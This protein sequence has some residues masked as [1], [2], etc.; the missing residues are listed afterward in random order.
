MKTKVL[1][2]IKKGDFL[3]DKIDIKKIRELINTTQSLIIF[4]MNQPIAAFK[5]GIPCDIKK[6]QRHKQIDFYETMCY[7]K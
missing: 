2:E 4:R 1:Y 6:T 7:K 5:N 3:T